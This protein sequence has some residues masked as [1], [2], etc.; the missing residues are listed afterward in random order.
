MSGAATPLAGGTRCAGVKPAAAVVLDALNSAGPGILRDYV[1]E[2]ALDGVVSMTFY[3]A[4][5]AVLRDV[6]RINS[7][8]TMSACKIDHTSDPR[9]ERERSG[10]EWTG[11]P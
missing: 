5:L 10:R 8:R 6:R 1:Y 2:L 4:V 7:L 11:E 3:V 9:R